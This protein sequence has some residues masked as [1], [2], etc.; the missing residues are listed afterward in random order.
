[1]GQSALALELPYPDVGMGKGPLEQIARCPTG[2]TSGRS[3]IASGHTYLEA[4]RIDEDRLAPLRE[5]RA[6]TP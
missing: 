5:L 1:M 2:T 4:A 3:M 6:R